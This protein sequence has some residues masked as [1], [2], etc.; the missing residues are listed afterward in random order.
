MDPPEKQQKAFTPFFFRQQ[1][2][3][4]GTDPLKLATARLAIIG[5]FFACRSCEYSVAT[6]SRKT[7]TLEIEDI[8]FS[9]NEAG[10]I[11]FE[12]EEIWN[13]PCVTYTFKDQK[14]G[15]KYEQVTQQATNDP[16]MCPVRMS[17]AIVTNIL[18]IKG[19]ST[20]SKICSYQ[21]SEG[22]L[23][24]ITQTMLL[25]E[26]RN[27]AD[28]I[29]EDRLGFT[30]QEIGTHSVRSSAA[31]SMF[32]ANTPIFVIM[33]VGRWS[34]DAFLKYIRRQVLQ[35]VRGVSTKMISNDLFW[36]LPDPQA[37]IEDPRTRNQDSFASNLSSRAL[38]STKLR[39]MRPAFSLHN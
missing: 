18:N 9:T 34:S 33:M 2:H 14:N 12:S 38:T 10:E 21:T 4:A 36:S 22:K 31:M 25:K 17:A 27:T 37:T 28:A 19:A 6:S 35:S 5:F 26:H 32:L 23:R 1:Y 29:G 11:P 20:K 13:A 7:K 24:E 15:E 39:A 8:R 16:V 3:R 30:S